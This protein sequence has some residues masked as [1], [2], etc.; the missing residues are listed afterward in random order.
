[1]PYQMTDEDLSRPLSVDTKSPQNTQVFTPSLQS[2]E[3]PL[4][5]FTFREAKDALK[6][7]AKK[8]VKQTEIAE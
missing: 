7:D 5:R 3:S 2:A 4:R 8:V 1:M 6:S